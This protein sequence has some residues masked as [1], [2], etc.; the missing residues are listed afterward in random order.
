MDKI[1]KLTYGEVLGMKIESGKISSQQLMYLIIGLIQGST[2]T[3]TFI[4]G[5]TK[6]D[7]WIVLIFSFL[8]VCL[9]LAV[10]VK[11]AELFPEKSIIDI[12]DITYGKYLGK[13]ISLIYIY[14][15]WFVLLSNFRF[16]A[17][18][19]SSFLMQETQ[20]GVFIFCIGIVSIY[21]VKKGIE[22]LARMVP[23]FV[24]G[25]LIFG[26]LICL[27][28]FKQ[29]DFTNILPV[30]Q[31]N[32]SAFVQGIN[33]LVAIPFGEVFVF[34]MIFP[35]VVD[36]ENIKRYSFKGLSIG[37]AFFLSIIL[38]DLFALGVLGDSDVQASYQ[39]AKLI[40]IGD[41]ITRMETII[42]VILLFNVFI[43][44]TIFSYSTVL[45]V[46]QLLKLRTYKPIASSIIILGMVFSITMFSGSIN[47]SY[48][49]ANIYPVYAWIPE[50]IF[51][52]ASL[53]IGKRKRLKIQKFN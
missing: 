46:A 39:V 3:A 20:I 7:T 49:G 18:F 29:Y 51:P 44:I 10:Y 30:L 38:R 4:V 42:A 33:V 47:Q 6:Q 26:I 32:L 24:I 27:L 31:I 13:I 16:I 23:F 9:M 17:D 43:K 35:N 40:D 52:L 22:T 11:L 45:G 41:I 28:L 12:N 21:V 1:N 15:F 14:H 5:V 34:L 37:F 25:T 50:V 48:Y 2:L 8:V 53:I 19:Y 36:K